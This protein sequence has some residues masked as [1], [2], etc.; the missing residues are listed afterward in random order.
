MKVAGSEEEETNYL[1][2]LQDPSLVAAEGRQGSVSREGERDR[3]V[4]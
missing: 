3:A 4:P 2:V 1:G